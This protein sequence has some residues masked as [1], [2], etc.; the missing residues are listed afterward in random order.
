MGKNEML[1]KTLALID[2][3]PAYAKFLAQY[4]QDQGIAVTAFTDSDDFLLADNAYGFEF[5]VVDLTL[6]GVDGLDLVRLLNRRVRSGIV[7]VSGR[8]GAEAFDDALNAGAD[9][10]LPKPVRF[11]QVANAIKAVHRRCVSTTQLRAWRLDRKARKLLTPEQAS[12]ALGDNDLAILECFAVAD[13][14]AVTHA[15]LCRQLGRETTAEADNWL[16]AVIYRL[17]RRIE[18]VTDEIVP[19]QSQARVGYVFR[20]RLS[21]D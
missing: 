11:Q 13:G 5:Y 8:L 18:R 17:R 4:L 20:W 12:V 6:P 21:A 2:D 3:D 1:P 15:E 19:L 16:H 9:M 7:V 10:Y 14:N